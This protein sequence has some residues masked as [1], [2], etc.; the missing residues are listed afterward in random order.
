MSN[1][2]RDLIRDFQNNKE[3]ILQ[4]IQPTEEDNG[5]QFLLVFDLDLTLWHCN[6]ATWVEMLL[7]PVRRG[8]VVDKKGTA[9]EYFP[10]VPQIVD[11]LTMNDCRWQLGLASRTPTP[12]KANAVLQMSGYF[13]KFPH[14][15]IYPGSK[16]AH[17]KELRE[18]TGIPFENMIFFD[19][20]GRNI[21]EVGTLGVTAVYVE[22]VL[23]PTPSASELRRSIYMVAQ[24]QDRVEPTM[25]GNLLKRPQP[26]S[27]SESAEDRAIKKAKLLEQLAALEKKQQQGQPTSTHI[28]QAAQSITQ[29]IQSAT[30]SPPAIPPPPPTNQQRP[31]VQTTISDEELESTPI[32]LPSDT[33]QFLASMGLIPPAPPKGSD[34]QGS[35]DIPLFFDPHAGMK[36]VTASPISTSTVTHPSSNA[37]PI[38]AHPAPVQIQPEKRVLSESNKPEPT[39]TS[40]PP[41]P[42]INKPAPTTTNLTTPPSVTTSMT[43]PVTTSNPIMMT[44]AKPPPP[45]TPSV[46]S[47]P[48]ATSPVDAPV[49]HSASKV[50]LTSKT[51]PSTLSKGQFTDEFI[52]IPSTSHSN[53]TYTRP[54]PMGAI[55]DAALRAAEEFN[56]RRREEELQRVREEKA[57]EDKIREEKAREDKIREEKAREE[58]IREE[59]AREE[60]AREEKARE[61]KIR[62]ERAREEKAREDK[63]REDKAREEKAREDKIREDKAREEKIRED[64]ARGEREE[65]IRE[66]KARGE[67]EE[68]ERE[69]REGADENRNGTGNPPTPHQSN[70]KKW[71]T[72]VSS[73]PPLAYE[74]KGNRQT[75]ILE[76]LREKTQTGE[77]EMKRL[78]EI[79]LKRE[80]EIIKLRHETLRISLVEK[81]NETKVAILREQRRVIEQEM[82]EAKREEE[83]AEEE[84][85][86]LEEEKKAIEKKLHTEMEEYQREGL[87]IDQLEYELE[88]VDIS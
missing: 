30:Q 88:V 53:N 16:L 3:S 74:T 24:R 75:S 28:N 48:S 64:K 35:R 45:P 4:R 36:K 38:R 55:K 40:I 61:D 5:R 14:K 6:S 62:E 11:I 31:N 15:Q 44:T 8:M 80:E 27:S 73:T 46:T 70:F 84:A 87:R 23:F 85:R 22:D 41:P 43:P 69:R 79:Y 52:N 7:M 76:E 58:K 26:A 68:K 63:I 33:E 10:D 67:R 77:R 2:I 71:T 72:T 83:S 32:V 12:H 1:D 42:V 17:F 37:A 66:E 59:K 49:A 34:G 21:R 51:V 19:D 29:R 25:D 81:Q 60:K 9:A 86:K 57:R 65:R 13:D 50:N 18:K 39:G 47:N 54:D 20:E 56:L 78:E 82:Q